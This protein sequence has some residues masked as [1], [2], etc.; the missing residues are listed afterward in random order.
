V[1]H[2]I[3]DS[4]EEADG[5]INLAESHAIDQIMRLL[6]RI[7]CGSSHWGTP[8]IAILSRSL[9]TVN[10]WKECRDLCSLFSDLCSLL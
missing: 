4:F 1:G 5:G 9:K 10:S 7:D 3:Q 6:P 8:S 2:G